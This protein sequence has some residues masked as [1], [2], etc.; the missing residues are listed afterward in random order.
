[1]PNK[2]YTLGIPDSTKDTV[3]SETRT[4]NWTAGNGSEIE[5]TMTVQYGLDLQGIRKTTGR[6]ELKID[7]KIDGKSLGRMAKLTE[8]DHPAMVAKISNGRLAVGMTK[9]N[10][11]R[12]LAALAECESLVN[13]NNAGYDQHA[14]ELAEIEAE[15]RAI[16]QV[17]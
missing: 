10:Y 12:Y 4:I 13:A 1:M 5:I 15:G 16:A 2:V 8:V 7:T 6:L 9:V 17:D 14:D 11:D 3:M